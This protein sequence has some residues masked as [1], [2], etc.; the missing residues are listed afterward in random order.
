MADAER[1]ARRLPDPVF[2][3]RRRS[4]RFSADGAFP[5]DAASH[6]QDRRSGGVVRRDGRRLLAVLRSA[7]PA[8]WR[9]VRVFHDPVQDFGR[10][11]RLDGIHRVAARRAFLRLAGLRF[12]LFENMEYGP[13]RL[14]ASCRD[15]ESCGKLVC[16]PVVA[17]IY[18]FPR[19]L[20]IVVL[21]L[22]SSLWI[23][24]CLQIGALTSHGGVEPE[25]ECSHPA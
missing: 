15:A 9:W 4:R 17:A 24:L 1:M 25:P 13:A 19:S 21:G 10:P 16:I 2:L 14:R 3:L 11:V 22:V 20:Q 12:F 18:T 23:L 5:E 7:M 8:V 6:R